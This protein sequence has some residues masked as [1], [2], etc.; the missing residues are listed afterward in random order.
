MMA[1]DIE[2]IDTER[3][4]LGTHVSLCQQRY[5]LLERRITIVETKLDSLQQEVKDSSRSLKSTIIT[6]GG[7]IVIAIIGATVS[8]LTGTPISQ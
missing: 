4:D 2:V 7:A 6:T 8:I 3:T 5:I 1:H